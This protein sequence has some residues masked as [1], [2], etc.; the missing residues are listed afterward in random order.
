MSNETTIKAKIQV[1][2]LSELEKAKSLIESL[3]HSEISVGGLSKLVSE[4]N[5]I[6]ETAKKAENAIKGLGEIKSSHATNALTEGLNKASEQATK[7]ES[8]L[9]EA[10]NVNT[11]SV[12]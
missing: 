5:K 10:S 8:K 1:S 6:T 9:K 7:L 4:L 12:G 3:G 2:G 11:G